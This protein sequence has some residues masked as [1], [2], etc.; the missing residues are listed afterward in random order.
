LRFFFALL[1]LQ[2]RAVPLRVLG[3]LVVSE[4]VFDSPKFVA[5]VPSRWFFSLLF[6]VN[7]L[8]WISSYFNKNSFC[9]LYVEIPLIRFLNLHFRAILFSPHSEEPISSKVEVEARSHVCFS[10]PSSVL[11]IQNHF[12]P[13][14]PLIINSPLN[15]F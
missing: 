12:L 2:K 11:L 3:F 14:F 4:E 7:S 10:F 13:K 1:L 15:C 9:F 8:V 6:L 5:L